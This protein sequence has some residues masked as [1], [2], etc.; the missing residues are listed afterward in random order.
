M[1][2]FFFLDSEENNTRIG[3][4]SKENPTW[5]VEIKITL[6]Y[7]LC[8]WFY[9]LDWTLNV[10]NHNMIREMVFLVYCHN[11]LQWRIEREHIRVGFRSNLKTHKRIGSEPT[12]AM[13]K[14]DDRAQLPSWILDG[15]GGKC[16]FFKL[17]LP[18][19]QRYSKQ[20]RI[21]WRALTQIENSWNESPME[22]GGGNADNNAQ[23]F[24]CIRWQTH[25]Y[26]I[27]SFLSIEDDEKPRTAIRLGTHVKYCFMRLW[28]QI[29]QFDEIHLAATGW[30]HILV[31]FF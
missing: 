14:V 1:F 23:P 11:K 12:W 20:V 29:W 24:L 25:I 27:F 18:L 3:N 28:H 4:C 31:S 26:R 16:I 22:Y 17:I 21:Q 19:R 2:F 10:N 13:T 15:N 5:I 30:F 6:L 7:S 8:I 9:A